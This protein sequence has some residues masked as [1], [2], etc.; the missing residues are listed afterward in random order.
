VPYSLVFNRASPSAY[1]RGAP[2]SAF[3]T[4]DW[5]AHLERR[6]VPVI[7]GRKVFDY[8][9]SKA[10]QLEAFEVLGVPYPRTLVVSSLQAALD[11]SR[12]L[13]F[14]VLTKANV[15]GSGA[16]ITRFDSREALDRSAEKG[17][18]SFGPDGVALL[19]ELLTPVGGHIVRVEVLGGEVLYAIR[20]HP[21]AG[22]F[23]LCPA[24]ACQTSE[25]VALERSACAVDAPKNGLRVDR[26]DPPAEVRETVLRIAAHVG[27]DV[28]GVEYLIDERTGAPSYYDVNALSN[29]VADAPRVVGL[30]PFARLVDYLVARR[31]GKVGGA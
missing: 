12:D 7:N 21:E 26:Y 29:F 10:R 11:A 15:G 17:D 19:Q 27:L 8:E 14:P 31:D 30:D 25:G 6:G 9:I 28:G 18:V 16:G 4:R 20:V 3:Y 13:R 1:L 5:L 24:D 2:Q 22:S 23:N